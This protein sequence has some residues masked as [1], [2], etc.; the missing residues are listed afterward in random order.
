MLSAREKFV[1]K[2]ACHIEELNKLKLQATTTLEYRIH[3]AK[4]EGKEDEAE[5][6]QSCNKLIAELYNSLEYFLPHSV[7]CGQE[8]V[9][10]FPDYLCREEGLLTPEQEEQ[11]LNEEQI[12]QLSL[13]EIITPVP[14]RHAKEIF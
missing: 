6:Y 10:D 9:R 3:K 7:K 1:I 2:E 4:A 11:L 13:D 14:L 8:L 12:P 5:L